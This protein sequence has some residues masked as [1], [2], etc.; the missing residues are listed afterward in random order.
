MSDDPPDLPQPGTAEWEQLCRR[1]GRCCY[2]KL[3]Y[4]GEIYYTTSPCS[5]LNLET[6]QCLV[7]AQR[8]ELQPDCASLTTDIIAMGVL[9]VGC[10]YRQ[11]VPE[12]PVPRP[13][14]DLPAGLQDYIQHDK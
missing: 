5:H 6:R 12:A 13:A 14:G 4:R 1:C 8:S 2:E 3:D 7:Y 10:P 11:L 9:P